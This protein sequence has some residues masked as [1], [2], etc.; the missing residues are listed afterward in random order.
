MTDISTEAEGLRQRKKRQTLLRI[1]E[2]GLKLFVQNGYE[3][4]T[5]EEIAAAAGISRRTF[6]YYFK[7]KEAILMAFLDGGFAKAIR[8]VLLSQSTEQTPFTATCN[9]IIQLM[10]AHNREEAITVTRLLVSTETLK[11]RMPGVFAEM[12][13]VVYES[14]CEMWPEPEKR[15]S[16]RMVAMAAIGAMRVA[17]ENWLKED[18]KRP[19]Q[20]YLTESFNT[21]E[22]EI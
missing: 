3:Q 21:L 10:S 5:L 8:P 15:A 6:F 22:K 2:T 19:L 17:K 16:L 12:E 1:A 18:G 9:S 4:T 13:E 20:E 7:S 11:A 14:L